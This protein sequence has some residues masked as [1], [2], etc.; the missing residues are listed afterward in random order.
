MRPYVRQA[1][2]LLP[3]GVGGYAP[4]SR[5]GIARRNLSMRSMNRWPVRTYPALG[6]CSR[7]RVN[8]VHSS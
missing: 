2:E 1:Q 7:R 5:A 8:R 6:A 4:N 3:G